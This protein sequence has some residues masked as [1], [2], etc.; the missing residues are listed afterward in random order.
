MELIRW[1]SGLKLDT[2]Y[3]G[4]EPLKS[5]SCVSQGQPP[6]VTG[7]ELSGMSYKVFCS[8]L[9]SVLNLKVCGRGHAVN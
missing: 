8:W 7:P 3:A 1:S 4:S 2:R 6:F 5:D 9:L